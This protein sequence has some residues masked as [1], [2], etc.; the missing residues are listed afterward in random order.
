MAESLE[1]GL[2]LMAAGMGTV[3]ALLAML[4]WM[5]RGMSRL[6]RWLDPQAPVAAPPPPAAATND[7]LITVIGAAISAFKR[8][9]GSSR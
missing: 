2:V 9:G 4:V 5:V 7:E 6:S 3:F 8:D 1:T